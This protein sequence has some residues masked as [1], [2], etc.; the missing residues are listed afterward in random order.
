MAK[1]QPVDG[2]IYFS[3]KDN[4][5]VVLKNKQLIAECENEWTSSH[6]IVSLPQLICTQTDIKPTESSS[7]TDA[8]TYLL[9]GLCIFFK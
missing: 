3:E 8:Q 7:F 2:T 9:L 5:F 4:P 6:F 1:I